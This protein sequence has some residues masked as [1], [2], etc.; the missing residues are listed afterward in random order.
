MVG[1]Q[2]DQVGPH[3]QELVPDAVLAVQET[4]DGTGHAVRVARRGGRTT[5]RGTVLVAYGDT[6]L[7]RGREPARRSPTSTRRPQR[8]V[9]ILTGVVANPFGY[10]RIVRNAE[11]DVEAI[12]EEKDA[13]AE[14]RAIREINCG[15]L[16]FDA[17]FLV[18]ALP[19]IGNDNAKGEYYLT[20]TVGLAR[21][22]RADRRRASRSTTSCRP[23]A[24]TTAPS[25]PSSAAS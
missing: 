7:L 2:R 24:P 14:Q 23:R 18:D 3:I 16:A 22:G 21:D 5:D 6:P 13:T 8:A 1:H 4:Q 11:G 12:V 15:I 25:S 17:E 19:R 10:G 20:D 9:S